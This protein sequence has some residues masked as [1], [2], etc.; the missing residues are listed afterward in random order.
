MSGRA[1]IAV[2]GGGIAGL[3]AAYELR[4]SDRDADPLEIVLFEGADRLGGKILT[5]PLDGTALDAGPDGFV[6]HK[7]WLR[8]LC[9]ELGL[10]AELVPSA[11]APA[12]LWLHGR[13]RPSPAGLALGVPASPRAILRAARLLSPLGA[14]R[15]A[16]DLALPARGT[17]EDE[18]LGAF[19]RRRFGVEVLDRLVDPLVGAV[20][21]S[22]ADLLSVRATAPFLVD[23]ESRA[24]SVILGLGAT[25]PAPSEPD[26]RPPF[27]TVRGGLSRVVDA[28][29][30]AL[31]GVDVRL[32]TPV[33]EVL[34]T[35]DGRFL[36]ASARGAFI[37]DAVVLATPAFAAAPL[38]APLSA[39]AARELRAIDYASVAIVALRYPRAAVAA[40]PRGSGFV[41][42]PRDGR[43]L[44]ACTWSSLKWPHLAPA[45]G[46]LVARCAVGRAGD[47]R[48]L[49]LD[50]EALV[51]AVHAE[52]RDAVGLRML[53]QAARVT[54]WTHAL[55]RY[56]VGHL[57]RLARIE[58]ALARFPGLVL[59]GAAYRG[60]G[61]PDCVRQGREAAEAVR[62]VLLERRGSVR[63]RVAAL[64]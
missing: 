56:G 32:T 38:V 14:L 1:R 24:R 3:A 2:V 40:P 44:T 25:S 19:V 18:S 20:Y 7:P 48:A 61:L 22:P 34:P 63:P 11:I 5:A 59:A 12:S 15:A 6:A 9:E 39:E 49:A 58:A 23:A 53:P 36:I 60:I 16:A 4:R 29:D 33:R 46:A 41:V 45:D 51:A 64:P 42:A 47:E 28:L 50:D 57:D 31:D 30:R 27:L 55:P 8:Q 21:A 13:L 17:E 10:A 62:R 26:P 35:G 54:R 43:L 37:A 52:L